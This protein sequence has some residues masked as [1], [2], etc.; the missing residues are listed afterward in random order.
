MPE[1]LQNF[2]GYSLKFRGYE[3]HIVNFLG[4]LSSQF[5]EHLLFLT[6]WAEA[7][8]GQHG[9]DFF[10]VLILFL[11]FLNRFL[12][13]LRLLADIIHGHVETCSA[14]KL[15]YSCTVFI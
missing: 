12:L 5:A 6:V 2:I 8:A 7:I 13:V 14:K 4:D 1:L 11:K 9:N 3:L 10:L 15:I